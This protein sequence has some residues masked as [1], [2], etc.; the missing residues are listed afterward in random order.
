MNELI[1]AF[2]A[3]NRAPPK[4]QTGGAKRPS[5]TRPAE[6]TTIDN[7]RKRQ[8]TLVN[9][10]STAT[11]GRISSGERRT[12][13]AVGWKSMNQATYDDANLL[14]KLYELRR[15]DTMRDARNWFVG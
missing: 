4:S 2:A 13:A 11:Q 9:I 5:Q 8:T 10:R 14:L 3:T 7:A 6:T 1:R 15:E 12:S